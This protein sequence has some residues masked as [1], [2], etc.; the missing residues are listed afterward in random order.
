MRNLWELLSA[1]VGLE[2]TGT[3]ME[4]GAQ[5]G[6]QPVS[7]TCGAF[8]RTASLTG[9]PPQE[10]S[11]VKVQVD[12]CW[13]KLYIRFLDFFF[14]PRIFTSCRLWTLDIL[15]LG[16]ILTLLFSIF[17]Q[18]PSLLLHFRSFFGLRN[19]FLWQRVLQGNFTVC[20]RIS[21]AFF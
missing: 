5:S 8:W 16:L 18:L 6:I 17:T 12:L 7:L 21:F 9:R 4:G 19:N 11:A 20:N 13:S 3:H 1:R 14:F 15:I 10:F 2:G